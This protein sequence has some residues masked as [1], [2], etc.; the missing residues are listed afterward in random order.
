MIPGVNPTPK[1]Q[2]IAEQL[3][4]YWDPYTYSS[5]LGYWQYMQCIKYAPWGQPNHP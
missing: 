4:N 2:D 3:E 1:K 5:S